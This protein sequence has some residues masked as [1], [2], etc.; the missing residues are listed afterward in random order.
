MTP[1][2]DELGILESDFRRKF[3]E[4]VHKFGSRSSLRLPLKNMMK[5]LGKIKK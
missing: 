3:G 4:Q 5:L 1:E 2:K